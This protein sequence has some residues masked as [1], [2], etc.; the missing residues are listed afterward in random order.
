MALR[1]KF[2][3]KDFDIYDNIFVDLLP[4]FKSSSTR[5]IQ[6]HSVFVKPRKFY[7]FL[8]YL[9]IRIYRLRDKFNC[10]NNYYIWYTGE[11]IDPPSKY[12]LTLSFHNDSAN[13]IYWPLWATY[14]DFTNSY[15]KYDREFVLNQKELIAPREMIFTAERKWRICAFISNNV[16]WRNDIVSELKKFQC[17]D[18]FGAANSITAESKYS[19]AKNYVFQLCFENEIYEGYVTEKPIEAWLCGNIPIYAGGDTFGY[20]N[21]SAMIDCS[22]LPLVEMADYIH[23][24]IAQRE[25]NYLRMKQP[26]LSKE[27]NF[28][29]FQQFINMI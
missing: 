22:N 1:F 23:Q 14:L 3:W 13:N 7:N 6:I 2:F 15:K 20:L 21:K 29:R 12:D 28:N 11:L 10:V 9:R 4:E 18:V 5:N 25:E 16:A 8:V 27:F 24:K 19:I 26:I 17:I